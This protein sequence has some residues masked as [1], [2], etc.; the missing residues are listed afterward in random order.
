MEHI[1]EKELS[2]EYKKIK[3]KGEDVYIPLGTVRFFED[4]DMNEEEMIKYLEENS[5]ERTI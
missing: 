1:T 5:N 3:I 2:E 4:N